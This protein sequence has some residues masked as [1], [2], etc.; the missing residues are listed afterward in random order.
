M[1]SPLS[2]SLYIMLSGVQCGSL[3]IKRSRT[4][5]ISN[6]CV[7]HHLMMKSLL[8]CGDNI[9][10]VKPLEVIQLEL[11]SEADA[12]IIDHFLASSMTLSC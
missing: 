11:E 9:L 8:N 12:S 1:R 10:D 4:V 5:G 7:S 2:S 3:C 6:V